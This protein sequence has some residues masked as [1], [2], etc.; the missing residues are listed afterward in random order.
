VRFSALVTAA[1]P[2]GAEPTVSVT[3]AIAAAATATAPETAARIRVRRVRSRRRAV[4]N[5]SSRSIPD[6]MSSVAAVSRRRASVSVSFIVLLPK[7][8][9]QRTQPAVRVG[10]DGSG[11]ATEQGRDLGLR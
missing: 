2:D 11:R 7:G 4:L 6:G 8:R 9:T 1:A 5:P 3:A 10:F